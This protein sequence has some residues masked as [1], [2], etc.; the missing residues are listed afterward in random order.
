M[1]EL[2]QGFIDAKIKFA[3]TLTILSGVAINDSK[4][5]H[6][7]LMIYENSTNIYEAQ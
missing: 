7:F 5:L 3:S 6:V 2:Q 1:E 4:K